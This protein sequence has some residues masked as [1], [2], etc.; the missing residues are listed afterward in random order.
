MLGGAN[1]LA[2]QQSAE[3][4][5]PGTGEWTLIAT[6]PNPKGLFGYSA[7]NR[8]RRLKKLWKNETRP[9]LV[10][11]IL[12]ARF[13]KPLFFKLRSVDHQSDM[14]RK[15]DEVNKIKICEGKT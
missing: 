5:N 10:F 8:H 6:N 1:S 12:D 2:A 7:V 15:H 9:L 11:A 13:G 4:Y 3:V 14:N